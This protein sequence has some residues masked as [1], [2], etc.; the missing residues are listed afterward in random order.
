MILVQCSDD[1]INRVLSNIQSVLNNTTAIFCSEGKIF[2]N[3]TCS[4]QYMTETSH[5]GVRTFHTNRFEHNI[6]I[7]TEEKAA[8]HSRCTPHIGCNQ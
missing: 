7:L 8:R 6:H 2:S 1:V 4:G 5:E 3:F